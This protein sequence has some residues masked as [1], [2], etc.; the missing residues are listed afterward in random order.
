MTDAP[1]LRGNIGRFQYLALGFGTMIGSA[2][3][4]LLGDWLGKAGPGG[5]VLGFLAGGVVVVLVGACY[6]E[7]AGYL[8]EAGSEFI[9]ARRVYGQG[10]AFTVGWFLILY[11]LSVTVFEAIAFA[12]IVETVLPG[13]PTLLVGIGGAVVIAA[14]NL[15]GAQV[16][17]I[18]HTM[19]TYSFFVVMISIL[20]L[21]LANGAAHNAAPL[22]AATNGRD[23]WLGS[24][25]I[26]A[27]C[28]YALNGF[29]TIPH[30]VE[31][32]SG[33]LSLRAI[34]WIIVGSIAAAAGFYCLVVI[35]ASV[36]VP[37]QGLVSAPLP[38][39]AAAGHL[40][41]G[42]VFAMVLLIA[43]AVSLL[44]AWNGVFM[45]AVRLLIAMARAGCVPAVFAR[46][47]P[48]FHSPVP[49]ILAAGACNIAGIFLGKGAI[50]PITDMSAM[51]LTLTYGLCCWTVLRIRR[52]GIT[53]SSRARSEPT[54][55]GNLLVPGG[56]WLVWIALI[57]SALM[58]ACAFLTPFWQQPGFPLEYQLLAAWGLIGFVVGRYALSH[59]SGPDSPSTPA[60]L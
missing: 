21:L 2:W 29:Q 48:R 34:G 15:C 33:T 22:F 52:R 47:H 41:H 50:E 55:D 46:L 42:Q 23:W 58:A 43:T 28:A 16:A 10:L 6:A 37:W 31:E 54:T 20:L 60:P 51:V 5:A 11:L 14:L 45:M 53:G 39:V 13:T 25:A 18:S 57:G 56:R 8:P 36:I 59:P 49:A 35:A 44:K 32:R 17:V 27:F 4:I 38:M 1:R 40:P 12:W 30:A 9:Y 19:L 24:G 26:F 7:L 3:V